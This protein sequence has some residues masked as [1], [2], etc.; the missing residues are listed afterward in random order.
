MK[1]FIVF[2]LAIVTFTSCKDKNPPENNS[3]QPDFFSWPCTTNV[4]VN[5]IDVVKYFNVTN[6]SNGTKVSLNMNSTD[7]DYNY[8]Y[9]IHI[10]IPSF[11]DGTFRFYS[12]HHLDSLSFIL[13]MKLCCYS[14][15]DVIYATYDIDES[16]TI[17]NFIQIHIDSINQKIS[18]M[19][20]ATL[21]LDSLDQ[22][23]FEIDTVR[24]RCDTFNCNYIII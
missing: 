10:Y 9:P 2:F 11:K 6:F 20:R 4:N 22:T 7:A 3:F 13:Y 15:P 8:Y 17:N 19:F 16:D 21:I 12:Q 23:G 14:N 1:K 5:G 18:G 24:V